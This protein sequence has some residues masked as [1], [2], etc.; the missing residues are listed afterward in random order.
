MLNLI[1]LGDQEDFQKHIF[2]QDD[3]CDYQESGWVCIVNG[4][5]A[6]LANYSHCSCFGTRDCLIEKEDWDWEGT[7]Y[8]LYQIALNQRDP[9]IPSRSIN[10]TDYDSDHLG[11]VY[12]Q[13]LEKLNPI[14][15]DP[16]QYLTH[17]DAG[18]REFAKELLNLRR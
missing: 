17:K 6:A 5:K 2:A 16:E 12:Q 10:K 8:E 9:I 15:L 4:N 13:I 14:V 11:Q 3:D 7:I 1:N 18:I